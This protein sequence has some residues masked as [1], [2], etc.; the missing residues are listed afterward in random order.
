M[1]TNKDE[2]MITIITIIILIIDILIYA[3]L[4]LKI[5]FH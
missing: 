4:L 2:I 1:I 3:H 5:G